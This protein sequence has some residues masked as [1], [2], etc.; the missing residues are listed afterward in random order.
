MSQAGARDRRLD[1]LCI[2]VPCILAV[3]LAAYELS[4]RSLWLD[5]AASVAI[6]SQHGGALWHA[7]AHDGGNMLAYYLLLH[8]LIG[9]FGTAPAAIRVVSVIATG[10]TVALVS[11]I[12]LRLFDRS[13]AFS[14]ATL[15]AVSLPLIYWGQNARG[16]ALMVTF[17]VGSFLAFAAIVCA[18]EHER[19]PRAALVLYVLSTLLAIYMGLIAAV[20]VPAQLVVILI[21]ARSRIRE[22][23][24]AV[25]VIAAGCVPLA[26]LALQRGSDQLFWVPPPTLQVLGQAARTLTSAGLPPNF[27][28]SV[29]G[30]PTLIL[31]GAL[32][33][34]ALVALVVSAR[35]RMPGSG[36]A[37]EVL[38]V[39]WLLVPA[40]L[41]VIASKAGEPIELARSTVL[42][43]PAV[44]LALAWLLRHPRLPSELGWAGVGVLV[45]L[46][47]LQL[48][49]SYGVSPE[50]WRTVSAYV[51]AASRPDA[52]VA[53]YPQD[54]R[55]VFDYYLGRGG[56]PGAGRLTPVLPAT[57]WSSE[58]P[59]VE[60][61]AVPSGA[62]LDAIVRRCPTLWLI[63]SHEGL[64]HG[65]PASRANF[66]R[67]QA[68]LVALAHRYARHHERS[69]GWA[70]VIRVSRFS[71]PRLSGRR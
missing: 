62:A 56:A 5:E 28:R 22:V 50:P 29:T 8:A 4:T 65:P 45:V 20:I 37:G 70:A 35:R 30:T 44:A 6:A 40:I 32:L 34:I 31:T 64:R 58:Q 42:L 57:P 67:Y 66:R 26:V 54:G 15:T 13:A 33:L 25:V 3:L 48:V 7:I 9:V 19:A 46:R 1:Q 71:R 10:A 41:T 49:P 11:L 51:L 59:Y 16:Y 12:G 36:R 60:R 55:M 39:S 61:Y 52:C 2:F 14:A 38:V 43:A 21:A 69:F 53:F 24:I 18:P 27:H 68:L 63:A 23:G 47:A 17:A